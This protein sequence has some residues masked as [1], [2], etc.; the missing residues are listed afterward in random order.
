LGTGAAT[1]DV[2]VPEEL[3]WQVLGEIGGMEI[4]GKEALVRLIR[5]LSKAKAVY[6]RIG[7]SL[8]EADERGY[9]VVLPALDDLVFEEPEL[10]R[11]GG[12]FGVRLRAS[13]PTLHLFRTVVSTEVAPMIG[14]EK[15]SQQLV[16]YLME[17]FEDDPRKIW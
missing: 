9:A 12:Q 8:E 14:S 7:R 6:D 11:K 17:K 5:D 10:V 16:N 2:A 13:A 3:F 4:R 15:Q 1:V